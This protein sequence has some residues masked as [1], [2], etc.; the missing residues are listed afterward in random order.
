MSRSGYSEYCENAQLWRGAVTKAIGGKRGQAFLREMLAV[1]DAM[2]NKRLISDDLVAG[3]EV[4]AIGA[5]GRA[6][7][8][9]M[10]GMD[11]ADSDRVGAAFGIAR[12]MVAEIVYE[13]DEAVWYAEAPEERWERMRQWVAEQIRGDVGGP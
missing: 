9:D 11:P 2:E 5:V 8:I 7:G 4:C 3:G 1:L 12:V 10:R 13:N 6:R